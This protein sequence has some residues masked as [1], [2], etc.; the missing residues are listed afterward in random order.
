M[1]QTIPDNG[2]SHY[3]LDVN[4]YF[5]DRYNRLCIVASGG[6]ILPE[7]YFSSD[8]RNNEFHEMVMDLPQKFKSKRNENVLGLI[9]EIDS[10]DIENYF[11]DFDSLAKR[12][13]YVFDKL[14]LQNPDDGFYLLVA[15]PVYDTTVDSFP[16][17]KNRLS[18]IPRT[19]RSIITRF[20]Q[21]VYDSSF[22]PIGLTSILN[23]QSY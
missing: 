7:F 15:Y 12:G 23:N 17:D 4:W 10:E 13:F 19:K 8:Y 18:L 14:K 16:I 11:K 3:L 9:E 21:E 5:V 22:N 1:E 6:G 20:N 2:F